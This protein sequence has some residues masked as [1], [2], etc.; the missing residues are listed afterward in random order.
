VITTG[1]VDGKGGATALVGVGP[2]GEVR[3]VKVPNRKQGDFMVPTDPTA[4]EI[5]RSLQT[6]AGMDGGDDGV[7]LALLPLVL[8]PLGVAALRQR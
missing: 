7:S 3:S 8:L 6:L 4:Q 2:D 1:A 5:E